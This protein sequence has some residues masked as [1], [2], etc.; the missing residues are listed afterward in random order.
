MLAV[1]FDLDLTQY[2]ISNAFLN[3]DLEEEIYME[4]PPGY[5]GKEGTCL[6]LL[7]G[8]YGLKQ[9]ARIWNIVLN[10]VLRGAGLEVCKTE[11]GVLYHP[12]KLCYVCLHVDDIIIATDDARNF[13]KKL[14]YC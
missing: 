10:K 3:G 6:K 8:L 14:F 9:A 2:D 7:K 11:P 5:P 13:V 1:A 4:Y 12:T